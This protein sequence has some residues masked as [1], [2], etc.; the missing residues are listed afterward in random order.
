ALPVWYHF[1]LTQ[2]GKLANSKSGKCLRDKH[3]VQTVGDCVRMRRTPPDGSTH[4]DTKACTC[5]QCTRDRV[6]MGCDNPAR[7]ARA[8]TTML[9][10]LREKWR[11]ACIPKNDGLSLTREQRELTR[12]G[13]Q[14]RDVLT[15]NPSVRQ[16]APVGEAFRIFTTE[17]EPERP[18][19]RRPTRPFQVA[20]EAVEV[21]TDGSCVTDES[22]RAAA[23]AGVWF[24]P[25]DDRNS[26]AKV[27]GESQTNQAAEAYA[28]LL[29]VKK[30]PNFA[31]MTI[32]TD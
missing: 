9:A 20:D 8:A 3:H 32:V 25:N 2:A 11:P 12:L 14:D 10:R 26:S 29:A 6:Q 27:P 28:C 21:Y 31:P 13:A 16:S 18:R 5:V 22:G 15:F 23:G 19:A 30:T 1:A 17:D 7:C 4:R 24:G